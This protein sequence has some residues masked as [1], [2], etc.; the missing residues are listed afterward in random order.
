M[1]I[2]SNTKEDRKIIT[3]SD[4]SEIEEKNVSLK[5]EFEKYEGENLAKEYEW[6]EPQGKEIC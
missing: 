2:E 6:D 3:I 5:E 4:N 1:K